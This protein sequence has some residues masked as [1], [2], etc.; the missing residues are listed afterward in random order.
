MKKFESEKGP[1]RLI[2]AKLENKIQTQPEYKVLGK[3]LHAIME[4]QDKFQC[5]LERDI[6]EADAVDAVQDHIF[7]TTL[8]GL[9]LDSPNVGLSLDSPSVCL[10]ACM[11]AW[12]WTASLEAFI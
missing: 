6:A 4:E 11:H 8:M 3:E 5:Q 12:S 2:K 1:L 7:F 9:S 10:C